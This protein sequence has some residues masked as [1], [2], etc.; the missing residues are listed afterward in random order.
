MEYW[1][2]KKIAL[3]FVLL[4]GV[5]SVNFAQAYGYS[6]YYGRDYGSGSNF[7][8]G[9]P[10]YRDDYMNFLVS[11][12]YQN[13]SHSGNMYH[14]GTIH[15]ETVFSFFGSR[16][17]LTV[18]PD[19]FEFSPFGLMLFA[20]AVF[21]NTMNAEADNPLILLFMLC[22]V[23]AAQWH[24]PCSD[25]IEVNLGWDALKFVKLKNFS[26]SFY[27]AGSLNAGLTGYIGD[28]WYW[29]VYY[30]FNHNHNI[31]IS[32]INWAVGGLFGGIDEQPKYLN[33]HSFGIRTG[34]QF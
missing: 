12:G 9:S 30:E 20:P 17:G 11:G 6:D 7:W 32:A 3:S 27:V 4:F 14:T 25:H 28:H 33:G 16:A 15:A 22:G 31:M 8:D 5:I 19:Y 1:Y 2:M 24:I 34:W 21:I 23:S 18:G 10:T 13:L 26:D 29:N